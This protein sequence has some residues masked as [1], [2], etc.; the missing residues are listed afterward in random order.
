MY[1][2][3][4]NIHEIRPFSCNIL[5]VRFWDFGFVFLHIVRCPSIKKI[6]SIEHRAKMAKI[7]VRKEK[8]KEKIIERKR[9]KG[10]NKK[11]VRNAFVYWLLR[12]YMMTYFNFFHSLSLLPFH[13]FTFS[14]SLT[15]FT[16]TL[17]LALSFSIILQNI[18]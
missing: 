6:L 1:F 11:V 18:W 5:H 14:H 17:T 3:L 16:L 13:S 9:K 12:R 4:T 8:K 15:S 10:M 7:I 2:S